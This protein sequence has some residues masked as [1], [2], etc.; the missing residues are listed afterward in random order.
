MTRVER[1]VRVVKENQAAQNS[2]DHPP[3]SVAQNIPEQGAGPNAGK[4]SNE[5][6]DR[7][8]ELT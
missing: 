6:N 1:S 4:T 7:R 5:Q 3:A 8:E 2:S